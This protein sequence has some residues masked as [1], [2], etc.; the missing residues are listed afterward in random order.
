MMLIKARPVAGDESLASEFLEMV[1][2]FR[3]PRSIS[4]RIFAEVTATKERIERE[5]VKAGE[6]ERNVKLG[7][8]G[9]REIEFVTQ[10]L[11]LLHA[12]RMPF[13]QGR[14]TLPTLQKFVDYALLP[15]TD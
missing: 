3:Y 9:I 13:L 14:Q 8:G 10:A 1:Q 4:E 6:L 5:V 15:Q 11:Q 7:H 2:P 12:G